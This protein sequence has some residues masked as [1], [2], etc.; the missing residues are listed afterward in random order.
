L[1]PL[2]AVIKTAST[3]ALGILR[4][5]SSGFLDICS[6]YMAPLIA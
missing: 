4:R 1:P 3:A 2:A 5:R 6:S